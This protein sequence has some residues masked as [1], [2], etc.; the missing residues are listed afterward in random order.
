MENATLDKRLLESRARGRPSSTSKGKDGFKWKTKFPERRSGKYHK[1]I[2]RIVERKMVRAMGKR[3]MAKK[4]NEEVTLRRDLKL[5]IAGILGLDVH[6][7]EG[8]Y[9]RV[10][11]PK[12]MRCADCSRKTDRKTNE[13]CV[14]CE[15][16][17][18]EVHRLM[19][20]KTCTGM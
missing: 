2:K 8:E 15:C 3:E 1:Y 13:G 18:C 14:S 5:G 19:F 6:K 12:R 11:L 10:K 9:E 7:G 4:Y 20:C 17:I 16:P